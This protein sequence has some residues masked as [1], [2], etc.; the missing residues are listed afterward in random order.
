MPSSCNGVAE[1]RHVVVQQWDFKIPFQ[2]SFQKIPELGR[3][4]VICSHYDRMYALAFK[5]PRS[6]AQGLDASHSDTAP[7]MPSFLFLWHYRGQH[8]SDGGN[9]RHGSL[10]FAAGCWTPPLAMLF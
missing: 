3:S 5:I 10:H 8:R 7:M 6:R 2:F 1:Q 4:R 9:N